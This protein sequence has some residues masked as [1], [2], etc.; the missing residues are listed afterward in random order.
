MRF[1]LPKNFH[2]GFDS[3][4][5]LMKTISTFTKTFNINAEESH[6]KNH[7]QKNEILSVEKLFFEI[8]FISF[9]IN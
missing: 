1:F 8:F 3:F 6:K 4:S 5:K 7:E 9:R 2:S